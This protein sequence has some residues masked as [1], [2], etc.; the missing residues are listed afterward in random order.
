MT[1]RDKTK[2][3]LFNAI[4]Y[5]VMIVIIIGIVILLGYKFE[6]LFNKS[7]VDADVAQTQENQKEVTVTSGDIK[8]NENS[9][10]NSDENSNEETTTDTNEDTNASENTEDTKPDEI[11]ISNPNN[12]SEN[13]NTTTTENTNTENNTET[14]PQAT[15]EEVKIKIPSGTL[16]GGMGE[17]LANAGLVSSKDEFVKKAVEMK[18]DRSLK[19]GDFVFK[20]G[21]ALDEIIRTLAK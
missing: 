14:K 17:I 2:D 5:V 6:L 19:S 3:L 1:K 16:P 7:K 21:Q 15:G 10:E 13:K 8:T 12:E 4:D 18:L 11:I 9:D 20:K